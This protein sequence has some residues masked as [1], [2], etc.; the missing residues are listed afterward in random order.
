MSRIIL[1]LNGQR[2]RFTSLSV[3]I[4]SII[5]GLLSLFCISIFL[6]AWIWLIVIAFDK[7]LNSLKFI[8]LVLSVPI[9]WFAVHS[10]AEV[11]M[12]LFNYHTFEFDTSKQIVIYEKIKFLISIKKILHFS[13]IVE[14]Q[15]WSKDNSHTLM[16][17]PKEGDPLMVDI[18]GE[19][20]KVIEVAECISQ[21][22]GF[23]FR[24][25]KEVR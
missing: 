1:R 11:L 19:L 12:A 7:E 13:N 25:I 22:C 24:I 5:I 2:L 17:I 14:M 21:F 8:A 4:A 20:D 9:L 3:R 10:G 15:I 23:N 16:L 6:S 18:S